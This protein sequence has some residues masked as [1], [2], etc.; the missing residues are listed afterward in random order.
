VV[1]QAL[2]LV[3][4]LAVSSCRS[5]DRHPQARSCNLVRTCSKSLQFYSSRVIAADIIKMCHPSVPVTSGAVH[6]AFPH[7]VKHQISI[8]IAKLL[9]AV[10]MD[11]F[12]ILV[13]FPS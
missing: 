11:V 6:P 7:K 9:P 10:R 8:D 5:C 1:C 12:A 2:V 4:D 13:E 3:Q